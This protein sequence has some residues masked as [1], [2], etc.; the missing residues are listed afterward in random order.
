VKGVKTGLTLDHSHIRLKP[1]R[2]AVTSLLMILA[3]LSVMPLAM[4]STP[5]HAMS[6]MLMT[7]AYLASGDAVIGA[8]AGDLENNDSARYDGVNV[9]NMDR[10]VDAVVERSDTVVRAREAL[11]VA[12]L[13]A[14][15]ATPINSLTVSATGSWSNRAGDMMAD[16]TGGQSGEK[17]SKSLNVR[18]PITDKVS[19]TANYTTARGETTTIGFSYTPFS[20]ATLSDIKEDF[21]G[22]AV[23]RA[24]ASQSALNAV[25]KAELALIEAIAAAKLNARTTYID[26]L[27]T[28]K[29]REAAEEEYRLA[30]VR[31]EIAKRRYELGLS[32]ESDVEAA[33]SSM[34]DA[35]ISLIRAKNDE[36]WLRRNLS[37]MTGEVMSDAEFVDLP[38]FSEA[39]PDVDDL[40]ESAMAANT[41]LMQ[42]EDDV[43]SA[44]SALESAKSLLPE[45][46]IDVSARDRDDWSPRVTFTASW[47]ISLSRSHEV[48]RA[49]L[50]LEQ[51]ERAL[52]DI[53]ESLATE[54]EKTVDRLKIDIYSME[55]W[56]SQLEA[57]EESYRKALDSYERGEALL[58]DV[59]TAAL[60][61][62]K[63]RDSYMNSWGSVWSQ[64]YSLV[65]KC[66]LEL[67]GVE[68][69]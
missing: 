48:N 35:E 61:L 53:R 11:Y 44:Q 62:K 41:Q 67:D 29:S 45:F 69:E 68:V 46:K 22:T 12:Q 58:I 47:S 54:I 38:E 13:N 5:T 64:W 15:A 23:G 55:R 39:I 66:H 21:L 4:L 1:A 60:N 26:A 27:R 50:A 18:A 14:S 34:L 25:E 19:L 28:I 36:E 65:A 16:Q 43:K 32:P 17:E 52:E 7:A 6:P 63:T 40:I 31:F 42:A 30:E 3:V 20:G 24:T 49:A 57:A 56:K 33:K 2:A 51:K 8:V 9:W 37:K 59:D 10:F